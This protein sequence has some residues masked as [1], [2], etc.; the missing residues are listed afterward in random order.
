MKNIAYCKLKNKSQRPALCWFR[1]S[2][3][4]PSKGLPWQQTGEHL[5]DGRPLAVWLKH[6]G[7]RAAKPQL[8]AKVLALLEEI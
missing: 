2:I 3:P 4:L 1:E 6:S 7:Q 5:N 8:S